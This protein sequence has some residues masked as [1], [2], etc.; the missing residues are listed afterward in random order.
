M[1]DDLRELAKG[2]PSSD[3]L[4]PYETFE[5]DLQSRRF[6]GMTSAQR[7]VISLL[8]L[9]AVLVVGSTCLIITQKV[10]LT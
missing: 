2:S 4:D 1:F 10:W 6:L 5:Q 8:L 3:E 9:G 7:F